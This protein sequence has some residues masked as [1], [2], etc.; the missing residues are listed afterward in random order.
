M[1]RQA[2]DRG[3][4]FCEMPFLVM[5][6]VN[7]DTVKDFFQMFGSRGERHP[8]ARGSALGVLPKIGKI[9]A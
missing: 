2:G 7:P 1:F 8:F 5:L 4:K 9:A 6:E 3:L